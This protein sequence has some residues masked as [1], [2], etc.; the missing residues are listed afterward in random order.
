MPQESVSTSGTDASRTVA[1]DRVADVLLMFLTNPEPLG[2]TDVARSLGLSKAVVHRIL[3]SLASR[4]LIEGNPADQRYRPGAAMVDFGLASSYERDDS[5]HRMAAATLAELSARTGDTA[6]LTAR[7][8]AMRA[9]VDQREGSSIIRL[10]VALWRPRPLDVGA[11]GKAI[12]AFVDPRAREQIIHHRL[13]TH[14]SARR[15]GRER[16]EQELE[17]TRRE[18]VSVSRGEVVPNAMGVAAP[19]LKGDRPIG[20]VGICRS[21]M[22]GSGLSDLRAIVREAGRALSARCS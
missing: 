15:V 19:I 10:S 17:Q 2:V 22:N 7:I 5:W 14:D 6:T 21:V 16:L 13:T 20:A 3:Q 4:R 12:L 8:G 9:F 18:R 11:S 1:A